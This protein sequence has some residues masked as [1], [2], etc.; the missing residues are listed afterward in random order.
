MWYSDYEVPTEALNQL[1]NRLTELDGEIYLLLAELADAERSQK[2][3][4]PAPFTSYLNQAHWSLNSCATAINRV[5][6]HRDKI[7]TIGEPKVRPT[8][9]MVYS[10]SNEI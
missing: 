4:H 9:R 3:T 10:Q 2:V 5:I 7:R 8:V 1:G 6:D